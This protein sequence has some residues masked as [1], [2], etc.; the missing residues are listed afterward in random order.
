MTNTNQP[1]ATWSDAALAHPPAPDT[2]W[3]IGSI[4]LIT[5]IPPVVIGAFAWLSTFVPVVPR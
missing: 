4:A 1:I 3:V 5:L 2:A